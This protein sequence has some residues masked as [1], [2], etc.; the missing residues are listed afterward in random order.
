MYTIKG[1]NLWNYVD[2]V[3]T[4]SLALARVAGFYQIVSNSL[5]ELQQILKLSP[6]AAIGSALCMMPLANQDCAWVALC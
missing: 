1:I 4:G 3:L 6:R 2:N 5:Y